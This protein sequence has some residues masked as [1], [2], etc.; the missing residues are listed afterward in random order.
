MST[1][2]ELLKP[3]VDW[4]AD[5]LGTFSEIPAPD[6]PSA[7]HRSYRHGKA[8]ASALVA[9]FSNA[10]RRELRR[11]LR[12][13]EPTCALA[14]GSEIAAKEAD[15]STDDYGETRRDG[16]SMGWTSGIWSAAFF[17]E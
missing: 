1:T 12:T 7:W 15:R 3:T 6:S 5:P 16:F 17:S 13:G 2:T 11:M 4:E 9:T 10:T 14:M 8:R